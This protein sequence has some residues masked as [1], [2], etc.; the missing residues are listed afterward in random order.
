M[1]EHRGDNH[2]ISWAVGGGDAVEVLLL[3]E[4]YWGVPPRADAPCRGW[5]GADMDAGS[6]RL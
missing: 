4:Q 1:R 2:V 6:V 3:P 5:T